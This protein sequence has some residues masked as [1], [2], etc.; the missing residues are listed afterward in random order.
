LCRGQ[1]LI[2]TATLCR[3]RYLLPIGAPLIEDGALLVE[4][5]CILAIG[6]HADLAAAHP[7]AAA[8]D[9]G[10]AVLLPPLVN[11]HTHLEL[12][13][14]PEWCSAWQDLP[15]QGDFVG[16]IQHLIQV[17]SKLPR[18]S[19]AAAIRKGIRT[20]LRSGCGAVGDILAS[21]ADCSAYRESPLLGRVYFE[22]LGVEPDKLRQ[23]L[24]QIASLCATAPFG[25]LLPGLSPHSPYTLAP[26]L[27][28][29]VLAQVR[30]R[31][32]PVT[33]HLG[34]TADE[35][36]FLAAAA[37]PIV[38]RLYPYVG[39]QE[40]V[41]PAAGLRPVPWLLQHAP[42]PQ[43][44][45]LAHG[46]QVSAAEAA[47]LAATRAGVV[48]CPRS[49][50]RFGVGRAPVAAYH[51]AGVT[52]AL[53]TDSLA[54]SPSLSV[55]DELAFAR[56]WF[57]GEL[58]PA[59]WLEIATAGGAALLGLGERLGQLAAGRE[60]HFQVV[61]VP[62]GAR[63]ASLVEALC[64]AGDEIRVQALY[65]GGENVLPGC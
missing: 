5:G 26:D 63:A 23:Q 6:R 32:W 36:A 11:A 53:G 22:V 1:R 52:L 37:G 59:A 14:Y 24:A 57:A 15:G 61:D 8:S 45:L 17:K 3:A 44:L 4:G 50:A 9:F 27:F 58:D 13:S 40:R 39:W 30:Q 47:Q 64:A 56:E 25:R 12:S 38:E 48:L 21:H 18:E 46:V 33:M 35:V 60:A 16:W 54:S 28:T 34:E 43:Q 29:E 51:Q 31:Q 49:N 62:A 55:W 65:L 7:R 20:T 19:Y 2:M 10:D 42:L 41:P